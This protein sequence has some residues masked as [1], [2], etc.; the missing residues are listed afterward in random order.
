[1]VKLTPRINE[2]IYIT[3]QGVC[4]MLHS[5]R[6]DIMNSKNKK[7]ISGCNHIVLYVRLIAMQIMW[8]G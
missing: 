8:E 6:I 4:K 7:K 3:S 5:S 2:M 1:M